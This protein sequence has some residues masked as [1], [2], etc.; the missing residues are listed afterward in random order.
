MMLLLVQI[1]H[2]AVAGLG[3][4]KALIAASGGRLTSA[5]LKVVFRLFRLFGGPALLYH[6]CAISSSRSKSICAGMTC[7]MPSLCLGCKLTCE[8]LAMGWQAILAEE[9]ARTAEK[10]AR[11]DMH[12]ISQ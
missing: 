1:A 2:L 9:S 10:T 7:V 8:T 3:L 4:C 12:D 5:R 11:T 6:M